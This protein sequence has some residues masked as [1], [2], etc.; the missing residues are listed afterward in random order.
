MI[1][2]EQVTRKPAGKPGVILF[3]IENEYDYF[4]DANEQQRVNHL[5]A[6]RRDARDNGIDVPIFTCWTK[7]CRS[8]ND[9]ELKEVFD[10]P[11]MYP[12]WNMQPVI[13][14]LRSVRSEQPN[15]P[16]M[17]PE[18]Q[19]GWFSQVGGKLSEDQLAMVS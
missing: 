18:L 10:G 8:S 19:G 11:N 6:L 7:Q 16:V 4:K 3:Q 14:R 17:I 5:K 2:A 9:P 12:R 13:D 1:A 15:A